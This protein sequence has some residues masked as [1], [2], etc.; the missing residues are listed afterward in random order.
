MKFF[1]LIFGEQQTFLIMKLY[2]TTCLFLLT[3]SQLLGQENIINLSNLNFSADASEVWKFSDTVDIRFQKN[4]NR[5][6]AIIS[7]T[8]T[9]RTPGILYQDGSIKVSEFI[10]VRITA[11]VKAKKIK[12]GKGIIYASVKKDQQFLDYAESSNGVTG[13][14][15]WQEISMDLWI[16]PAANTFRLGVSLEGTGSLMIDQFRIKQ[17][18]KSCDIDPSFIPFMK[19]CVSVISSNSIYP[20]KADSLYLME[21]WKKVAACAD[22]I[23]EVQS[24]MKHILRIVDNHSFYMP[25]A[26]VL[27]WESPSTGEQENPKFPLSK[28]K[29]TGKY[30]YLWMPHF[31]SGDSA[32]KVIFADQMQHLI[33]SLDNDNIEGWIIDLR[34]NDGGNCWPMLAGI[35]PILGNGI[36]G[37]FA[38]ASD[39]TPWSTN[40]G[41]SYTG[42]FPNV[43]V[44]NHYTLKN[45]DPKVAV[46]VSKRTASSG[47]IVAL[48]FKNHP[49]AVLI[50]QKTGGYT[51][52]NTN[53]RLS[54][55]SFIFLASSIYMDR[56]KNLYYDGIEP[57][58]F[59]DSKFEGQ[60]PELKAAIEWLGRNK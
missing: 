50:G 41:T 24:T 1:I 60:D 18:E 55:G 47:E 26:D 14:S 59:I 33:D 15:D 17:I 56:E 38:S 4:D 21:A 39:S 31:A 43:K 32:T 19:E 10:Q 53:Y 23:Q 58:I 20:D 9:S 22:S 16:S 11:K 28:G 30:A 57:D 2:L 29:H 7:G 34:D 35:S 5:S 52:G 13:D 8:Y 37:Y 27:S 36:A 42:E 45:P 25:L 46:L 49:R 48:S 12:D 44:S 54:D 6:T 51:T 3:F 40:N